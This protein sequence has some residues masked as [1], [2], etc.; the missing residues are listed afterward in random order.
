MQRKCVPLLGRLPLQARVSSFIS[1]YFFVV[2]CRSLFVVL[3]SFFLWP[4]HCLSFDLRLLIIPFRIFKHF[5]TVIAKLIERPGISYI[6]LWV[7]ISWQRMQYPADDDSLCELETI[8]QLSIFHKR[9]MHTK[10][11]FNIPDLIE[12][13]DI[14]KVLGMFLFDLTQPFYYACHKLETRFSSTSFFICLCRKKI[15]YEYFISY[16][17]KFE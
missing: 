16:D 9:V 1:L 7:P 11:H 17:C 15:E 4:L 8:L 12:L 5:F 14:K 6:S 3:S 2:F 13:L 10:L